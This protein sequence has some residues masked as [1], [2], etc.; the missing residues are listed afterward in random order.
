MLEKLLGGGNVMF[1]KSNGG[2]ELTDFITKL[3]I[4]FQLS[5]SPDARSDAIERK[6]KQEKDGN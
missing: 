4:T 5:T 1:R 3:L 6:I 2:N